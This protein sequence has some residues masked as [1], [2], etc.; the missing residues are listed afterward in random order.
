MTDL[1][2]R[3]RR[4]RLTG[5]GMNRQQA[6]LPNRQRTRL[7]LE[8]LEARWVP[9]T[10]TN[11]NDAGAGSLR[12]A[13]LDTAAGGTVDFQPGLTGTITLRTGELTLDKDL[14]IAGPGADVLSVSG[15]HASRVFSSS[16]AATISGLTLTDGLAADFGGG[17]QNLGGVLTVAECVIRGNHAHTLGGGIET[18]GGRLTVRD[19]V[20][21]D[22]SVEASGHG[23]GIEAL[24]A[25]LTVLNTTV[26]GNSG[27]FGGG[28]YSFR[29]ALTV[30]AS[31]VSANTAIYGGGIES[32]DEPLIITNSTISGNA[33]INSGGGFYAGSTQMTITS[34]TISGNSARVAGGGLD[35]FDF[36]PVIRNTIVAGNRAPEGPDV[37][38]LSG[39]QGHNLIGDGTGATGF[40]DSDLVGTAA[41]PI[42]PRLGPLQDNGGPTPTMALL[43]GSPAIDA[44]D[45]AFS[46]GTYDQRGPGFPR[47]VNGVIDIGAFELQVVAPTVSC[48]VTDSLLW[49]PNH[50]LVNVGLSVTV[51]PPDADLQIRVYA[52]DNASPADAADIGPG[53]LQVRA[54]RQGSGDGRVYLVVVTAAN[55]GGTSF[56][57]CSVAVPHDHSPRSIAAAQQ[58]AAAA[59]AYYRENQTAPPSY[60]LL[61][62]GP[63][64]GSDA[65]SLGQSAKRAILGDTFRAASALPATSQSP[66]GPASVTAAAVKLADEMLGDWAALPVDGYLATTSDEGFRFLVAR[67]APARQIAVTAAA[68]DLLSGDDRLLVCAGSGTLLVLWEKN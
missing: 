58:Q 36:A 50:R 34:S 24:N 6:I 52:N 53:T 35:I 46:P 17:I 33:A 38:G 29:G 67:P 42:D 48:S 28:I 19:C 62:E 55:A 49:P 27:D 59:E 37:L 4:K 44:G 22:N 39:S 15:G 47:I 20:V 11:L 18:S 45:N 43:P 14:T 7:S 25:P 57:V 64:G 12:Q 8:A 41:N 66:L 9:S 68:L 54:E 1:P 13:I 32:A 26:R 51:D 21:E 56:D 60:N 10:V 61:G 65:P 63:G 5:F 31:T 40:G 16:A 2:R 3:H 23:A 30:I